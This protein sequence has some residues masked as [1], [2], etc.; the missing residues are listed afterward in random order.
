MRSQKIIHYPKIPATYIRDKGSKIS[1]K[2]LP[3]DFL[4]VNSKKDINYWSSF[5]KKEKN[6]LF[7][8]TH[9]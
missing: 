9:F 2:K 5:I 4:I 8:C 7:W 1:T 6:F 3:G